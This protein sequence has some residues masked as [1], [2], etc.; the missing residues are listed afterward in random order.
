MPTIIRRTGDAERLM[1]E[2]VAGLLRV[3][4]PSPGKAPL[5]AVAVNQKQDRD[6]ARRD[7]LPEQAF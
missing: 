2:S 5:A 3:K 4:T 1:P 6:T 7:A